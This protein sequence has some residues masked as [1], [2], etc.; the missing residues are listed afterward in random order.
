MK[1]T[2]LGNFTLIELLV[3]IAIIAILAAM[4][5]PALARAREKSIRIKCMGQIK[6]CGMALTAYATDFQDRLPTTRHSSRISVNWGYGLVQANVEFVP[7]YLAQWT[8]MDCPAAL[9]ISEPYARADRCVADICYM[10]GLMPAWYYQPPERLTDKDPSRRAL[11]GDRTYHRA[12]APDNMS[13]H[14]DGAN[15]LMLDGHARW[16]NY[17]ELGYYNPTYR[18]R[19]YYTLYPLP[20]NL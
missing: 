17:P 10:G 18:D 11:T 1:V 12:D 6:E 5:L 9:A 14:R 19:I 13:N 8:L 16:F 4:L 20:E 3:V 15:W 7:N 2:K